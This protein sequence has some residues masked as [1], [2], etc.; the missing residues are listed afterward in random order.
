MPA[1]AELMHALATEKDPRKMTRIHGICRIVIEEERYREVARIM[2]KSYNTIRAWHERYLREG[3][4]GLGDRPRPGRQPKMTNRKLT[5]FMGE[6]DALC[7]FPKLL[8]EKAKEKT[9]I[10]CFGGAVRRKLRDGGYSPKVPEPARAGRES[11]KNVTKW[12]KWLKPWLL[13][14][15]NGG[16]LPFVVDEC[17]LLHDCQPRRSLW[18]LV[19][20][21]AYEWYA[22]NHARRMIFGALSMNGDRAFMNAR[23]FDTET[24]IKFFRRVAARH[25]PVA[26]LVDRAT[27]HRSIGMNDFVKDSKGL[28][29]IGY[30]PTGWPELNPVESCWNT[31]KRQSR[32]HQAYPTVDARIAKS[33]E[34][35]KTRRFRLDVMRFLFGKPVAKI[36]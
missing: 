17:G 24:T 29:R 6:G 31:L 19:G 22:G 27:P 32:A 35:L 12:Q 20:E 10:A 7:R 4:K 14:A 2:Y 21:R 9:G 16:F 23:R 18:T 34:C 33:M 5:E 3:L 25:G 26:L 30:F 28:V 11:A 15:E 8:A 36:V 13:E 1:R